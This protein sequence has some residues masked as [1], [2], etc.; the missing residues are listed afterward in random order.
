MISSWK[1]LTELVQKY[2]CMY[3]NLKMMKVKYQETKISKKN[4]STIHF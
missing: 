2:K 3:Q 1:I 4:V